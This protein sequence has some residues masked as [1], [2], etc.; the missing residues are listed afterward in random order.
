MKKA[1][2]KIARPALNELSYFVILEPISG[3]P[4]ESKHR[5]ILTVMEYYLLKIQ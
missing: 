1:L 2:R 4:E 3:R 5:R